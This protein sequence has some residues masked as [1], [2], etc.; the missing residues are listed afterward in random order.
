VIE[1]NVK[2][3]TPIRKSYG[4]GIASYLSGVN[5]ED[6]KG[7]ETDPR[8]FRKYDWKNHYPINE[9]PVTYK[10]VNEDYGENGDEGDPISLVGFG[11]EFLKKLWK[12]LFGE[13]TGEE[14]GSDGIIGGVEIDGE[15][16]PVGTNSYVGEVLRRN[17]G[18][19][20]KINLGA[21]VPTSDEIILGEY[22]L[23]DPDVSRYVGEHEKRHKEYPLW[24]EEE[25]DRSIENDVYKGKL[26]G[27]VLKG[28]RLAEY[29]Y[30][31]GGVSLN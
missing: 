12:F 24:S 5:T 21:Y 6:L 25:V 19:S 10:H 9:G 17:G 15:R 29:L 14:Y 22:A 18:K 1:V 31:E 16:V 4:I 30:D 13:E 20:G 28:K 2:T 11:I 27:S 7:Y 3:I 26:P 23:V 8:R